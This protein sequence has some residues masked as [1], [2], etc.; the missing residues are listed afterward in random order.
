MG[1]PTRV[2]GGG[3]RHTATTPP[4]RY[5]LCALD[6]TGGAAVAMVV[7]DTP[8]MQVPGVAVVGV[9]GVL[10]SVAPTVDSPPRST[11]ITIH[12]PQGRGAGVGWW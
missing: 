4:R 9:P 2:P 6:W 1:L 12:G 3:R 10:H 5:S 11:T 8:R 7:G